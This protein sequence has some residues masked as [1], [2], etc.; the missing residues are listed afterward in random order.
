MDMKVEYY[1]CSAFIVLSIL[2]CVLPSFAQQAAET[3]A[4]K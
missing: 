3:C 2:L 1:L 4:G